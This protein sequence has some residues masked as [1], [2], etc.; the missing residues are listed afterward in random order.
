MRRAAVVPRDRGIPTIFMTAA[1]IT[2]SAKAEKTTATEGTN[3][4]N[5]RKITTAMPIKEKRR[6]RAACDCS[7]FPNDS[8]IW[9][10]LASG[11][12]WLISCDR[13]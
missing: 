11:Y 2:I 10:I 6:A 12:F 1:V 7:D 8:P 5:V 3:V 13:D 4:R 9:S